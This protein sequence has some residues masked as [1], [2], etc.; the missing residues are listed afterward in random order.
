MRLL[1]KP[2][3]VLVGAI[4]GVIAAS[5]F[6]RIWR[7]LALEDEAPAATDRDR[8]WHEVVLASAFRG[9]IFGAVKAATDRSGAAGYAYL[10]GTWPGRQ[11]A[12]SKTK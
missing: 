8:S 11:S 4:G 9:A 2:F 1:Y 10:T 3:G 6:K 12:V 7:V 5:L